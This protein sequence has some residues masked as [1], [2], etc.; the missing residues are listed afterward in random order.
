[1][2]RFPAIQRTNTILYCRQWEA[3]VAFYRD[4][5]GLEIAFAN[6]WMV[7]FHLCDAAYLSV[8]DQSRTSIASAGGK[9]ITLSFEIDGLANAQRTMAAD[10]LAP[11]AIRSRV[12]GADV[13]YV[14]DPEGNRIEFW[15]SAPR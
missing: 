13:F 5:L 11:T 4:R 14:Y 12:M 6:D 2:T 15:Q 3:T 8:A 10:G 1:M 7:E 9:G